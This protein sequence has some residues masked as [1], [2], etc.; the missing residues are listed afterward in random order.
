MHCCVPCF[1]IK[2]VFVFKNNEGWQKNNCTFCSCL[3]GKTV[4]REKDCVDPK[5][6]ECGKV[7]LQT[8]KLMFYKVY[9]DQ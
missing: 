7:C 5:E 1:L 3:Q 4:C 9:L 2:V 8:N 6:L